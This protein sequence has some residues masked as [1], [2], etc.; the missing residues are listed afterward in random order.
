M[1]ATGTLRPAAPCPSPRRSSTHLVGFASPTCISHPRSVYRP[2]LHLASLFFAAPARIRPPRPS[3]TVP[4]VHPY[5][6]PIG[7]M[8]C[9]AWPLSGG[10]DKRLAKRRRYLLRGH[11]LPP[12]SANKDK[13]HMHDLK[14]EV[15]PSFY[16]IFVA[17]QCFVKHLWS[18]Q[19]GT[20]HFIHPNLV[21][22]LF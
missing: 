13:S 8:P 17:L 21:L 9:P 15:L 19:V 12:I 5:A 4:G 14:K 6:R 18:L 10:A 11:S 22:C 2:R 20:P 3:E 7:W 1:Q 16:G